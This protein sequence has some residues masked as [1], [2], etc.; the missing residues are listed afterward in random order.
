M[1][2]QRQEILQQI[3]IHR[4]TNTT[5]GHTC[6]TIRKTQIA[7]GRDSKRTDIRGRHVHNDSAPRES[8]N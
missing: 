1:Q 2:E 8:S 6:Q 3:H 4:S 7:N 5:R